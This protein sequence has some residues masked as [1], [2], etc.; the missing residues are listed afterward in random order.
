MHMARN[1]GFHRAFAAVLA[2][3]ALT[4]IGAEAPAAQTPPAP[5]ARHMNGKLDAVTREVVANALAEDLA[6][7]YAY[8]TTG[9]KMATAIRARLAAGAY[10]G[11]ESPAAFASALTADVDAVAPDK[12]FGVWFSGRAGLDAFDSAIARAMMA[13]MEMMNGAMSRVEMLEGNIGTW[14]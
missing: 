3:L 12:H 8:A 11:I 1:G 9:G 13:G 6:R 14:K 7:D 4:G 2:A 10:N 5:S